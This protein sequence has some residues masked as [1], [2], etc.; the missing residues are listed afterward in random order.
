MRERLFFRPILSVAGYNFTKTVISLQNANA[1]WRKPNGRV[2]TVATVSY[3]SLSSFTFPDYEPRMKETRSWGAAWPGKKTG[4]QEKTGRNLTVLEISLHQW[5][6][7]TLRKW[8]L[9]IF[10]WSDIS[11]D[12]ELSDMR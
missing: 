9:A 12:V 3:L 2:S 7:L 5:R 11:A 10:P 6:Y 1:L 8:A 4:W